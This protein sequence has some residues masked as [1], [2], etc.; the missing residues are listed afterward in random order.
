MNSILKIAMK[1][2]NERAIQLFV[3]N[4]TI[5]LLTKARN[6]IAEFVVK[7]ET[8]LDDPLVGLFDDLILAV[9]KVRD[10]LL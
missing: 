1:F 2:V 7:T 9:V 10:S 8:D 4:S 5:K 6:R 3:L